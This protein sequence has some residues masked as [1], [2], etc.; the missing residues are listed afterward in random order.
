MKRLS[1]CIACLCLCMASVVIG[2]PSAGAGASSLSPTTLPLAGLHPA[3]AAHPDAVVLGSSCPVAAFCVVVGEYEGTD[4]SDH[5]LIETL[6]GGAW[7]AATAPLPPAASNPLVELDAVSCATAASCVAVGEFTDPSG[8]EQ[9][10]IETLADGMWSASVMPLPADANPD[11]V[12]ELWDVSCPAADQCVAV[13][14]YLDTANNTDVLIGTRAGRTWT[15]STVSLESFSPPPRPLHYQ[16]LKA[17]SCAQTG[18]CVAAGEYEDVHSHMQLFTDTLSGGV[19]TAR[20][21]ALSGLD[22][23]PIPAPPPNEVEPTV[24]SISCASTQWCVI[25][26]EYEPA[27]SSV[28]AFFSTL[29]A[30]RWTS[31]TAPLAGLVPPSN[32][33]P[34]AALLE[35]TCPQVAHCLAA[36]G[37]LDVQHHFQNLIATLSGTTWS[38]ATGSLLGLQPPAGSGKVA[39]LSGASCP[40][41]GPCLVSGLYEDSA[42][43]GLPMVESLPN[44]APGYWEVASDGGIFSF[45]SAH[46]GGSMGGT[47]LNRPVVGMASTPDGGGYWE[48]ASDGGIFSF[49][50]AHFDG[51]MGG[52]HLNQPVVG[53]A[54]TPDGDGYWE[55]A[56][57]GGIFSF[58]DAHFD[59]SMGGTHLN[60]PVVGMAS[61][62]DGH[63][64]WE[65]ASDGGI[66][67]F[68]DAH[69][70][71]SMGGTH[72]NRPVVG[73]A[74]TPDGHGYWEVASDGGI[75][76]FGDAR[77]HGSTGGRVLNAPVVGIAPTPDGHGYWEVASDG[78]IFSFGDAPF[79]GS[80]GG[81]VLNK[82]MVGIAVDG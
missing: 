58:G 69:F 60:Q 3:A 1:G 5:G 39:I 45:G 76:S 63:G 8:H 72:L 78:G 71:G 29:S 42:G 79:V 2:A 68:G 47:H 25:A 46:F 32:R 15:P 59:G 18:S 36:G 38:A 82:P 56:S 16:W 12:V 31:V 6:S 74:S 67:S 80:L 57:D 70:D 9:G 64:Y 4:H 55:V 23:A 7:S 11:P 14:S 52:T 40:P 77:Y 22:P 65:V 28:R 19:W 34:D 54:S 33:Q 66:F 35:V 20:L 73:M 21:L 44:P 51:S 17:V 26:G 81:T 10:L 49:G 48:V 61:T 30:G 43:G 75:F 62:P 41:T 53:M 13:G 27:T 37:Y 24:D 50:D